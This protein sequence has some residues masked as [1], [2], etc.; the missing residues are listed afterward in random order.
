VHYLDTSYLLK[1]YA[2]EHGSREVA[3]WMTG[4]S[5]F[6]CAHHG[7]LEL[8]A[9]LKRHQREGRIDARGLRQMLAQIGADERSRLVEWLPVPADL[10]D[11]AC[12]KVAELPGSVFLRA[13]DALHLACAADAGLKE[14]YSHDQHLLAAAPHFGLRGIDVILKP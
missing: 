8:F 1:L 3:A 6:V 4:R 14:I 7:R 11:S 12:R 10:I 13:A 5:H 2:Y 9:A